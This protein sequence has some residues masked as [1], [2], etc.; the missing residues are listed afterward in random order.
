MEDE[1]IGYGVIG[2]GTSNK[3]IVDSLGGALE[4]REDNSKY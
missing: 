4:D 1:Y 2:A 3:L